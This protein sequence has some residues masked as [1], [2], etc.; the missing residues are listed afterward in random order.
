MSGIN[1]L[2]SL[3]L[4]K[5]EYIICGSGPAGGTVARRLR[6]AGKTCIMLETGGATYDGDLQMRFTDME[7]LGHY[8][9]GHW[10]RHW[11]RTFGGTSTVWGG[12]CTPLDE[13]DFAA[14]PIDR[15]E[16]DPYYNVAAN[17]LDRDPTINSYQQNYDAG[18]LYKPFS[19]VYGGTRF[20][21]YNT[22]FLE[23]DS[24][25]DIAFGTTL[26]RLIPNEARTR[27][28]QIQISLGGGGKFSHTLS[29]QQTL[30]LAGGGMGNAQIMLMPPDGQS[31]GVG[32]ETDMVGRCLMEHPHLFAVARLVGKTSL[33]PKP[34]P[35][36]FGDYIPAIIPGD[37]IYEANGRL[38]M[39]FQFVDD[40][41]NYDDPVE[42]Y[43]LGQFGAAP[44]IG[45]LNL[46][47]EMRP[48]RHNRVTLTDQLDPA[49]LP[50][51]RTMCAVNSEDLMKVLSALETFGTN[52]QINNVGRL[53]ILNQ[54][55]FGDIGGGGHTMGTTRMGTAP[56][57]SVVDKNCKVHGY[58][59]LYVAG[60]SVFTTGG[61]S[62]PTLTIVA[63][64]ARLADHLMGTT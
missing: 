36:R 56:G 33:M 15:A 2:S 23:P 4:S 48:E 20:A 52:L 45:E 17:V 28:D 31:T 63:L 39:T 11:I 54:N 5:Y 24:L 1:D 42:R 34:P 49:G 26:T 29:V 19:D 47:S 6:D 7:T 41:R 8:G 55:L 14:W 22:D 60:S 43:L 35:Q 40:D 59:N 37:D 51:L 25:G 32:N 61:A 44:Y 27:V 21:E 64:A 18:F 13:R 38:A 53:L 58:N 62:N 30:I 50:L 10:A 57:D 16:L 46:R 12:W 9:S 3:D